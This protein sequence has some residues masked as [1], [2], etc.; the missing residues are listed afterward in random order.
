MGQAFF[1]QEGGPSAHSQVPKWGSGPPL[2]P[3]AMICPSMKDRGGESMGP[4]AGAALP[5]SPASTLRSPIFISQ[6]WPASHQEFRLN[7]F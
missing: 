2:P 4:R 7:T 5:P 3:P 1:S 6:A